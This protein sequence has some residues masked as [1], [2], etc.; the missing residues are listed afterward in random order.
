MKA[1]VVY[2]SMYGNTRAVAEGVAEGLRAA[3]V[4]TELMPVRD[5][6]HDHVAEVDLLVIGGPT[7]VHSMTR[8][9]TRHAAVEQAA[10]HG[11]VVED[12]AEATG[13]REWIEGLPAMSGTSAAAFDTRVDMAKLLSGQ[14]SRAIARSL[15]G[16]GFHVVLA[17]ES[18]LVDTKTALLEGERARAVA[19]GQD[20]ARAVTQVL[21]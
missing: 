4:E 21:A 12:D 8:P 14:A 15:R 19:W 3:A 9:K 5:A 1:L 20:L 17:P 2:E 6:Q 18:F 7:H 16:H 11:L 13:V 10:S